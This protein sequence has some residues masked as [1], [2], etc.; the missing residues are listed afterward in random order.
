[1]TNSYLKIAT[2]IRSRLEQTAQTEP[3]CRDYDGNSTPI[4]ERDSEHEAYLDEIGKRCL[5]RRRSGKLSEK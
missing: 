5:E 2:R 1:M 4:P 3:A